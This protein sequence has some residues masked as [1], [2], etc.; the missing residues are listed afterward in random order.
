MSSR[1]KDQADFDL[2]RVFDLFD[3]AL[4]SRDERVVNAL[5]SLLMI[6]A[7]TASEA[8]EDAEEKL[9]GTTGPLRRM[10]DDI[11]QLIQSL[12]QLSFDLDRVKSQMGHSGGAGRSGP[13]NPYYP[14][15]VT[16]VGSGGYG[17]SDVWS[18]DH[19]NNVKIK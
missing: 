9:V 2:E 16:G 6:T 15:S 13:Y 5:R 1:E 12:T 17:S 10:R 7:L 11:N 18:I 19:S 14:Y 3:T 4:T 8:N